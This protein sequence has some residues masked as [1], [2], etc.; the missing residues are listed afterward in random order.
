MSWDL[1]PLTHEEIEACRGGLLPDVVIDAW[2]ADRERREDL[3]DAI[4]TTPE[5]LPGGRVTYFVVD[6]PA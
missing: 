6:D 5:R 3:L 4:L 1:S 2:H